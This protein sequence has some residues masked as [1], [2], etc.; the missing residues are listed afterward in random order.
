MRTY[1]ILL[2]TSLVILAAGAFLA[3]E[4]YMWYLLDYKDPFEER[5]NYYT[6]EK[7]QA[8]LWLDDE[9]SY[10]KNYRLRAQGPM[11]DQCHKMEQKVKSDPAY[12]AHRDVMK[13]MR[14]CKDGDCFALNNNVY[15]LF[16][17][18]VSVFGMSFFGVFALL[19]CGVCVYA[20]SSLRNEYQIPFTNPV[21][22]GSFKHQC[23]PPGHHH[24]PRQY[25]QD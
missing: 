7:E 1:N 13:T 5:L 9:S 4:A 17:L 15:T 16:G 22:Q 18:L 6:K 24:L 23:A 10:C 21:L 25:K 3:R 11:W 14:W 2:L 12:S 8:Q 20:R 19:A